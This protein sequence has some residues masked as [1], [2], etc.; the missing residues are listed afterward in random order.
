M[1]KRDGERQKAFTRRAAL[2]G[3]GKLSLF[4]A[5]V[6]RM[7]YLQVIEADQYRMLAEENRIKIRL[8]PPPRGRILDRFGRELARNRPNFRVLLDPDEA[9]DIALTIGRLRGLLSLDE[10]SLARIEREMDR[11]HPFVPV[12]LVE[13]LGWND[14]AKINVHLPDLPGVRTD[15][16]ERRHYPQGERM[17]H[18]VGYVAVVSEADLTGDPVLTLPDFR[19]G[20][21]GA[22]RTF[23]L[24]LRGKAGNSRVEV[25]AFGREIRELKRQEGEPGRDVVLTLDDNLQ[26]RIH[27]RLAEESAAAVVLDVHK[28][29]V[30]AMTSTPSFDPGAFNRGLSTKAWSA[31][32]DNARKPLINKAI[33]GQYP[34][35]SVFKMVVALAALDSGIVGSGQRVFC[36]GTMKLGNHTFYCWRHRYGGHGHVDMLEA[37]TQSCDVYF[38][39][40]AKRIG[41]DRIADMAKRFGMDEALG[42][43]LAGEADGLV[44]N[45]AWKL[46]KKGKPWL[47]G[48]TLISGIGQGYLLVTPLQIAVMTARLATGNKTVPRLLREVAGDDGEDQGEATSLGLSERHLAIVREG[49]DGVVNG[50]R[51][52]G[53]RARLE[54]DERMAG[55]TGTAQVRRITK[56]ERMKGGKLAKETPWELRDHGLFVAYAPADAPRYALSLILEH[57]GSGAKA[58]LVGKDLMNEVLQR[59]PMRRRAIGRL[60][61]RSGGA[62][63]NG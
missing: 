57:G 55:K 38:Y 61:V 52:T 39:E 51:G 20:K 23:D 41:I 29:E 21:N 15:V 2:L 5:L 9:E 32:R 7:Y 16:G 27:G 43:E 46:A 24:D 63:G 22:E 6:G 13:N 1:D 56:A 11:R 35:G 8:L 4:G 53:R 60:A 45:R 30:L 28:G 40:I 62:E 59:D 33:A 25:N 37:I 3:L 19:I 47:Q 50:K 48:E 18:V 54:G 44:P 42:I 10:A 17:A 34:P 31:L 49:M 36:N 14:F 58:A 26:R 12:T